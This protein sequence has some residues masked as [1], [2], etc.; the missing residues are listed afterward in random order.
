VEIERVPNNIGM[1]RKRWFRF[2]GP[3]RLTLKIDTS[4]LTVPIIESTLT[5][6]RVAK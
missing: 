4:E 5:W 6:E 1:V 3:D 2:D